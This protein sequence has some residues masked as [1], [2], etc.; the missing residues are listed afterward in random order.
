MKLAN[1][2][3][4]EGFVCGLVC[5]GVCALYCQADSPIIPVMDVAGAA[6]GYTLGYE[7]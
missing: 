6:A 5:V 4:T 3:T 1:E 7:K 2:N